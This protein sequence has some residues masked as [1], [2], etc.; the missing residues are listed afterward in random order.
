MVMNRAYKIPVLA[1]AETKDKQYEKLFVL[2]KQYEINFDG[3]Y[4]N[5]FLQMKT[6]A[7][8]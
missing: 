5:N 6:Q 7:I 4:E 8:V 3:Q 2:M 1:T